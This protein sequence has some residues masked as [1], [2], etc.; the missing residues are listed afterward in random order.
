MTDAADAV[1]SLNEGEDILRVFI[2]RTNDEY[3]MGIRVEAHPNVSPHL[4]FDVIK[5]I[6]IAAVMR[7]DQ[8]NSKRALEA[9]LMEAE[10]K[11]FQAALNTER[12]IFGV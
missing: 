9:M 7:A 2:S 5:Q 12:E 3:G 10:A 6:I 11:G 8:V 1:A 4:T